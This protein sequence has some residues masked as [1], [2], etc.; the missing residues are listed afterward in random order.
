MTSLVSTP[1]AVLGHDRHN[2]VLVGNPNVGKSVFFN[3]LTG[4][5]VDV[6]NYP[7]TTVD[8]SKGHLDRFQVLDTP[9][10]YGVGSFNDEERVARDIVLGADIILNIV[11]APTLERDLFLT[12]QLLDM[13]K[14]VLVALNQMDEASA[15][16]VSIDI[17]RLSEWLGVTVIPCI[18]TRGE[19]LREIKQQLDQTH[20]GRGVPQISEWLAESESLAPQAER[21][22]A[23]EGDEVLRERISAAFPSRREAVYAARRDYISRIVNEVITYENRSESRTARLGHALLHPLGGSAAAVAVMAL[24]YFL[25][26]D[27]VAQR[28]VEITEGQWMQ[29][30]YEPWMKQLV[31]H[32]VP[33]NWLREIL[34]GEF[35]AL[36]MTVTYVVGLLLPLVVGFYLFLAVLED[37][38]YLPRLAV[39]VDRSLNAIGLNGRAIIP[40]IIGFGCVTMATI[41]TRLL[42]TQREKTIATA[43]LGLTIPCS[44]Q[45]GVILGLLGR[46]GS[47]SSWA[48]YGGTMFAVLVAV[49]SLLDRLLPG[50]SSA[51]LIDLP[52]LRL[53]LW[54]NVLRKTWSKSLAFLQEAVPLF[55][56]AALAVGICK[57]TGALTVITQALSPLVV[58]LLHLP[59]EAAS[60]FLM[61]LIR[62]DFGAAGLTDMA[63]SA[64]QTVVALV[65]IT[66]FVPCIATVVVL[67]KERGWR[68]AAT[69]WLGSWVLAFAIGGALVRILGAF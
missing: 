31:A 17:E 46:T 32:W 6:A 66:L 52:P 11:A 33:D 48:I 36:T 28:V 63:L 69:L 65:V 15:H 7:G 55:L 29:G 44:A 38:G 59:R 67:F 35:G 9:G 22:L 19:G 27:L 25:I 18:A 13:G 12:L 54:R 56:F 37:T 16:G 68:E 42:G 26:G 30:H 40:L 2:L 39:L 4:L 3:A 47:W 20:M 51:L 50:K 10:V 53:P 60:A 45:L 49:G 21:L 62:R 57:V 64:N 14:P 5:Y 43:I 58:G 1:A 8:V 41:T 23:L 24:L 34:V 61:G